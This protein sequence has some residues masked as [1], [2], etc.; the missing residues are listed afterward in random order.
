MARTGE[1]W[2]VEDGIL[3]PVKPSGYNVLIRGTDRYINF[4]EDSGEL[5]YG[6]RDNNGVIEKKDQGGSWSPIATGGSGSTL[7]SETP[8]ETVDGSNNTF[9]VN[10]TPIFIVVDGMIRVEGDGYTY[11]GGTITVD[12]LAPP[13]SFIESFYNA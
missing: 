12:E 11:S 8:G 6:F 13:T 1:Y 3:K 2:I 4:N 10:N 7:S 9:T 5:G